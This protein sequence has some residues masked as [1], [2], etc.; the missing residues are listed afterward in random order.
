MWTVIDL[1]GGLDLGAFEAAYRLGGRG[2]RAWDPALMLTLLIWSYSQG[3]RSSRRIERLCQENVAWR[4]IAGED[5]P[6]HSTICRF[7]QAHEAAIVDLLAQTLSVADRLGMLPLGTLAVDSTRI[8]AD[9]PM[10]ANRRREWL[11]AE[12]ARV[13]AEAADAD[14]AEADD[15]DWRVPADLADPKRRAARIREALAELERIEAAGGADRVNVTDPDSRIMR[16]AAGGFVQ[17]Y[18]AQAVV[19]DG[20]IVAAVEVTAEGTD[21]GWLCPMVNRARR[22]LGAAGIGRDPAV[23]LADAGYWDVADVADLEAAL[24]A[25]V[26]LVATRNRHKSPDPGPD[27][28]AAHAEAVAAAEAEQAA[29]AA[30]RAAIF[31]RCH[32]HDGDIRDYLDELGL[33]QSQA[34][35][36]YRHWQHTGAVNVARPRAAVARPTPTAQA[37]WTMDT[38]LADP[39]NRAHYRQR[40]PLI[41]GTF[42]TIKTRRAGRRFIRRGLDAVNAEFHLDAIAH[43]ITKIAAALTPRP[44]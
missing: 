41:E 32:A 3:V 29:E 14:D 23:V 2:R 22:N 10:A 24:P 40:G 33:S 34:Y 31:E 6:D 15:P 18:S 28:A 39:A 36:A 42:A 43:N 17:G 12:A 25:T 1:V 37:R 20:Q 19:A 5:P 7:R 35:A 44:A 13:L 21:F 9:A 26:V 30:R 16:T 4:V 11:E 27:P 38:R 8:E